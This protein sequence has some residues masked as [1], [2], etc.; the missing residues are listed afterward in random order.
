MPEDLTIDGSRGERL[1]LIWQPDGSGAN[2]V[3]W[4]DIHD[5]QTRPTA[6]FSAVDLGLLMATIAAGLRKREAEAPDDQDTWGP[7]AW[8]YLGAPP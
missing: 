1:S 4:R 5:L 7:D 8:P 2:I 6:R 3:L